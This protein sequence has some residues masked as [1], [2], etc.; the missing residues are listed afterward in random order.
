M[1]HPVLSVVTLLLAAVLSSAMLASCG[2]LPE[3]E[4]PAARGFV[5]SELAS[6]APDGEYSYQII[7]FTDAEDT[8][9]GLESGATRFEA[10]ASNEGFALGRRITGDQAPPE[11]RFV[12]STEHARLLGTGTIRL[13]TPATVLGMHVVLPAGQVRLHRGL[14]SRTQA[15][16]VVT[17]IDRGGHET[18]SVRFSP[19]F[20]TPASTR[21]TDEWSWVDLSVL[22]RVV[23]LDMTFES[24]L[25]ELPVILL[26]NLTTSEDFQPDT[27]FFSVAVLPSVRVS[28]GGASEP[29][30][31]QLRF[32]A[33]HGP[34]SNEH[35]Y[36]VTHLGG[37]VADGW[38]EE[39]WEAA[40]ASFALLDRTVPW[41]T[42]LAMSD[43]EDPED[44][45]MGSP[46][47]LDYFGPERFADA[48]DWGGASEDG[49]SSYHL[50]Q[51]PVGE[52]LFLHL[53]V[54]APD[55]TVEWAQS[56][57][58]EHRGI[59]TIV[60]TRTYLGATARLTRPVLAPAPGDEWPAVPAEELWNSLIWPSGQ[61]FLVIGGPAP[62]EQSVFERLQLS[63]NRFEMPVFEMMLGV[64][65]WAGAGDGYLRLLRFYPGRNELR[66]LTYSPS[67]DMYAVEQSRHF[68][69]PLDISGRLGLD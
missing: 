14:T 28:S 47:F 4:L 40:D 16:L 41:G 18:G 33:S 12:G 15:T 26:D 6:L 3:A 23:E 46:R 19:A 66:T 9:R 11:G 45:L 67:L 36:Y 50:V 32:L 64:P 59:P 62:G 39:Q 60:T 1:K 49:Y 8:R 31:E 43:L 24:P 48:P 42:A 61:V 55:P 10:S 65:D 63:R 51:T 27:R 30:R 35:V 68:T 69:V 57:L 20:S 37:M 25:A 7:D 52:L 56:V 38:D 22:G 58:E 54:D 53:A 13:Q 17:G 29:V 34:R 5:A 21:V 2:S 44:P